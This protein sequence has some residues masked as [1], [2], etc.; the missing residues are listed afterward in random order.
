MRTD[1]DIDFE[2][3][4]IG[5]LMTTAITNK[6]A[7]AISTR[8]ARKMNGSAYGRPYFAPTKPVLHSKTK[9]SGATLESFKLRRL[10]SVVL[11]ISPST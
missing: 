5:D 11:M 8:K 7:A 4:A 1:F 10:L 2:S 3:I 6:I 9:S